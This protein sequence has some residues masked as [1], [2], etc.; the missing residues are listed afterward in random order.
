MILVTGASGFIGAA[1][2]S[3]L[4]SRGYT[5]RAAFRS[6][7]AAAADVSGESIVVGDLDSSTDWTSALEG[8]DCVVHCAARVHEMRDALSDSLASYR[9]AN[10]DGVRRLAEQAA[11]A[12]VRRLLLL[13]TIKVNGE[14]T[15]PG[16]PF[17]FS[18]TPAPQGPYGISKLEAEQALWSVVA[19]T[20]LEGV[21]IRS[22][23]VYGPGAKGNIARFL[24]LVR[25]GVPLPLGSVQN[26]RSLVGLSNLVDF[27]ICC[28]DH[29]AAA[30]QTLLVSDDEDVSTA[31]LLRIMASSLGRSI[32]LLPTPVV[33]LRLA[34]FVLGKQA[35]VDRVIGSLQV[36]TNYSQDLL[37]WRPSFTL[38][39]GIRHMV[40][41]F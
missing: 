2:C 24:K 4:R 20:G 21:V 37:N 9:S 10:V 14:E 36:D 40:R 38:A 7:S 19:K 33:F 23:L 22:P 28:L 35:E 8:I 3:E 12:R 27:L 32:W 25:L 41:P 30:G 1:V 34:G 6:E 15:A 17:L 39:E 26:R 16:A 11:I 18:D 29:P 13:S 5:V 31:D